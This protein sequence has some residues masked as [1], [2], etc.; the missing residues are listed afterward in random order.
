MWFKNLIVY[1][2]KQAFNLTAEQLEEKLKEK[3]FR[4]C[5]SQDVCSYG[6]VSALGWQNKGTGTCR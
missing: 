2:F 4:Q 3:L 6:F 1:Q 5:G